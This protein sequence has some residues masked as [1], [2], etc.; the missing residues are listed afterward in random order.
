M[1]AGLVLA[2]A[3]LAYAGWSLATSH[4][5]TSSTLPLIGAGIALCLMAF[6]SDAISITRIVA[7]LLLLAMP[8]V[9]VALGAASGALGGALS[10]V[11]INDK[12]MKDVAQAK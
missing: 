5:L 6:A 7:V 3:G 1:P 4:H 12:F 10:D 11:G 8:V 2:V 9:G